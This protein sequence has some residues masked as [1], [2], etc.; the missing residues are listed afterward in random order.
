MPVLRWWFVLACLPLW[1]YNFS[2]PSWCSTVT[3][4]TQGLFVITFCLFHFHRFSVYLFAFQPRCWF[5]RVFSW[6]TKKPPSCNFKLE[7]Q[8]TRI[9]LVFWDNKRWPALLKGMSIFVFHGIPCIIFRF[10]ALSLKG[11]P[12]KKLE[13]DPT[14]HYKLDWYVLT[15]C[16]LVS[17]K[18]RSDECGVSSLGWLLCFVCCLFIHFFACYSLDLNSYYYYFCCTIVWLFVCLPVFFCVVYFVGFCTLLFFGC[19]SCLHCY[20]DIYVICKLFTVVMTSPRDWD[21]VW[22]DSMPYLLHHK[23]AMWQCYWTICALHL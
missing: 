10:G 4:C 18:S 1:A 3:W 22:D 12:C 23:D 8:H 6:S 9:P 19:V 14:Q 13:T 17:W 20:I 21:L 5:A 7:L 11:C 16:D 15:W 2:M